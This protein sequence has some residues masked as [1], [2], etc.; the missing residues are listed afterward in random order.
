MASTKEGW[1]DRKEKLEE[2][3][4]YIVGDALITAAFQSYSGPFPSE[5]REDLSANL[6]NK[7]KSLKIPYS[8]D[9][10]FP[11]FLVKPV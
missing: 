4:S 2:K 10:N 11:E 5:F 9:Y 7:I 8:K 6:H 3:Y 1:R